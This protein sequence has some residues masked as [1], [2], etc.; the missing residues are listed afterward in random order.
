MKKV[1]N[2]HGFT[3]V[4]ATRRLTVLRPALIVLSTWAKWFYNALGLAHRPVLKRYSPRVEEEQ[5][6]TKALL[7]SLESPIRD[8]K[9]PSHGALHAPFIEEVKLAVEALRFARG[10]SGNRADSPAGVRRVAGHRGCTS[11]GAAGMS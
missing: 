10:T 6:K 1:N 3:Q 9:V 4:R 7:L 2:T 5:E 8:P 11:I